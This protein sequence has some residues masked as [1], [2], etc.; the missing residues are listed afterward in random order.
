[1]V[2]IIFR[3]PRGSLYRVDMNLPRKGI[4]FPEGEVHVHSLKK[5][6]VGVVSKPGDRKQWQ[7]GM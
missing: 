3:I 4:F 7:E 5:R 6:L 1:M 2:L